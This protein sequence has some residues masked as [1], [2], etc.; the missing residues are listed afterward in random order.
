VG[1]RTGW[2]HRVVSIDDD[3]FLCLMSDPDCDGRLIE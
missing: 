2:R 1:Y 3:L